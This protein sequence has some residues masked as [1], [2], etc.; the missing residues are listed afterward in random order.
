MMDLQQIKHFEKEKKR[1]RA[2]QTKNQ[3]FDD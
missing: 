1:K 3:Y 2:R